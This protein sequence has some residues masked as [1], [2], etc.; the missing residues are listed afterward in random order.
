MID[1]KESIIK[2]YGAK[3]KAW[4]DDLPNVVS[5]LSLLW[6]LQ[7]LKVHENLS[8]NY[9]LDGMQNNQAIILKIGLDLTSVK[10]EVAA[11]KAFQGY[12]VIKLLNEDLAQ[13][14]LL[15]ERA[16]PGKSL[17]SLFPEHDIKAMQIACDMIDR[18]HQAPIPDHHHFPKLT[19]LLQILDKDWELPK[20]HLLAARALKNTLLKSTEKNVLLHGDLHYD[21]ILSNKEGWVVIDPKGVI[22]DPIFDKIGCLLREPL[23]ELLAVADLPKLLTA[24]VKQISQHFKVDAKKVFDWTYVHTVMAMCWCIEDNVDPGKMLNFLKILTTIMD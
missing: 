22:G 12:G 24:R 10:N 1:F 14:A 16:V 11:L 13:G 18:L 17:K 23:P 19:E 2:T 21:N 3:G 5:R 15:A 8:W 7:D 20:Q 4:L 6:H 9:I